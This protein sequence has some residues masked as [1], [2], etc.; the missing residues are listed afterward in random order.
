MQSLEFQTPHNVVGT[1]VYGLALL[2]TGGVAKE[3]LDWFKN[4][5]KAKAEV[6][7]ISAQTVKVQAEARQLDTET[8]I[9]ASERIEGLLEINSDLRNELIESN[10]KLDNAQFECRQKD[11]EIS[12][13]TKEAELREY[14]IEQL[15]AANKLGILLKDLPPKPKPE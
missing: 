10:R 7:E 5:R 3:L 11:Y 6:V 14:F 13:L 12:K 2:I 15:Q 8:V 4:H 9:R 1:I